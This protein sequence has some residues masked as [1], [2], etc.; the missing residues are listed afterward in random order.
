ME[1][2]FCAISFR[3]NMSGQHQNVRQKRV[4]I[5]RAGHISCHYRVDTLSFVG[6][7][8]SLTITAQ[9]VERG[10][11]PLGFAKALNYAPL[12]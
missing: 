12:G 10:T 8:A 5:L 7:V 4:R 6:I 3:H 1:M 2:Q 9:S 11:W